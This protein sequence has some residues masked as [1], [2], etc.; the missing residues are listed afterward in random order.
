[1]EVRDDDDIDGD[2]GNDT[3]YGRAGDDSLDG[4]EGDDTITVKLT[5]QW[6]VMTGDN[7]W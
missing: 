6:M 3:I 1:M 7:T 2:E 4:D 5:T